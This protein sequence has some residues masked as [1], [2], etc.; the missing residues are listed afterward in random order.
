[1]PQNQ[2]GY[3][4]YDPLR[5]GVLVRDDVRFFDNIPGYPR[6]MSKAPNQPPQPQDADFFT[7]FPINDDV[8]DSPTT[9]AT[10]KS[11]NLPAELPLHSLPPSVPPIDVIQVSSDTEA[12]AED[13][14]DSE[15]AAAVQGREL[16]SIADRV[17]ARR[18][19]HLAG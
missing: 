12:G 1:M 14:D 11:P 16:D 5:T 13:D 2:A 4:I 15:E 7:H 10:P 6:L 17:A 9:S 18:R 8:E 3:L 19:A